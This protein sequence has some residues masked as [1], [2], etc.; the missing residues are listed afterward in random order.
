M[1]IVK[2]RANTVTPL[3]TGNAWGKHKYIQSQSILGSL[4]FW[5]EILCY[6]SNIQVKSYNEESLNHDDFKSKVDEILCEMLKRNENNATLFEIKRRVLRELDISLPSQIF[7]CNG[8][9]GFIRIKEIK[10]PI[11]L[12]KNQLGLKST[13]IKKSGKSKRPSVWYLGIPYFWGEFTLELE[14]ESDE[15]RQTIL[16]PLL[17]F[18][19]K[20]GFIG[21]K[22]NLGYGRVKFEIEEG[23]LT[24]YEKLIFDGYPH[25]ELNK[26]VNKNITDF[27]GLLNESLVDNK[28]IGLY[29][30]EKSKKSSYAVII[31]ELIKNKS[32][33]RNKRDERNKSEDKTKRHYIFGSTETDYYRDIKGPNATKI[34]P[35]IDLIADD[36]YQYGYI[37]L[38]M[39]QGV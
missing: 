19:E 29:I 14:L 31:E 9:Q 39:L 25:I 4:R 15:L 6:T 26:V 12:K 13:I 38:I 32:D 33:E 37:S 11:R 3:W 30:K 24:N 16:Y 1:S 8:W 28:Q 5:F 21:G 20:Y 35:W 27:K 17:N 18:I 10:Q 34:I 7:G 2:I 22:N 23:E 36:M